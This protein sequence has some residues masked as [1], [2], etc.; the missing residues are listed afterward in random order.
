[1]PLRL[2]P[3]RWLRDP[4]VR[5]PRPRPHVR[6]PHRAG[7]PRR[8]GLR[9][10]AGQGVDVLDRAARGR[11]RSGRASP[12]EGAATRRALVAVVALGLVGRTGCREK[13]P[14]PGEARLS[15]VS[16]R[17]EAARAGQAW[18]PVH[19][20]LLRQGERLRVQ[21]AR[22]RAVLTLDGGRVLELRGGSVVLVSSTPRLLAGDLL[23]EATARDLDVDAA[24]VAVRLARD[25]AARLS[26]RLAADA[27]V[28]RGRLTL[29]SAGH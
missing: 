1:D 15:D 8:A 3:G 11:G 18:R 9:V 4:P 13:A 21:G 26:S 19:R 5:R 20:G 12:E 28:Y 10:H 2:H 7:P 29:S 16:G 23:A 17:V 25:T 24:S 6:R 14:G 27:A 22:G